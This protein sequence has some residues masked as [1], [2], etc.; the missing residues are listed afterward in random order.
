MFLQPQ[1][2]CWT[3]GFQC[4][5]Q[6]PRRR[7]SSTWSAGATAQARAQFGGEKFLGFSWEFN[8]ILTRF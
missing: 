2:G 1:V 5:S 4:G 7:G 6:R 3:R 8:G